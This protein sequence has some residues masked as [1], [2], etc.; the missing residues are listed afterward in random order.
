MTGFVPLFDGRTLAG[1]HAV[2]RSYGLMWPGGPAVRVD[3][4]QM[5]HLGIWS[6]PGA[7]FVCIEPWHGY[8]APQGFAGELSEKEG[9]MNLASGGS[10]EFVM[11]ITV[12]E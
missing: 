2:P 8:A 12:T 9:A 1:W 3:F 4:P 7:G 11:A 10:A 5:P 6:K